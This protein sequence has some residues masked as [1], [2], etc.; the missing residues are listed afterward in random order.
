MAVLTREAKNWHKDFNGASGR[1]NIICMMKGL[2]SLRLLIFCILALVGAKRAHADGNEK[3]E[4]GVPCL[5][6]ASADKP[7]VA[8]IEALANSEGESP[9]VGFGERA[10]LCEDQKF[11]GT[12]G[13]HFFTAALARAKKIP[14]V[15]ADT[16]DDEKIAQ[17]KPTFNVQDY[18]CWM[19]L[20]SIVDG[21]PRD[22]EGTD[23]WAVRARQGAKDMIFQRTG[24]I[25][26]L[27][28]FKACYKKKMGKAPDLKR[29]SST[30][31]MP[32]NS[33]D[34]TPFQR[35]MYMVDKGRDPKLLNVIHQNLKK[36]DRVLVVYG[37][38]HLVRMM[39]ALTDMMGPP[40]FACTH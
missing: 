30:D 17:I 11:P 23:D 32:K 34:A 2:R 4:A 31:Y 40:D 13:E 38:G 25:L 36:R 6:C 14:Y 26:S 1:A 37:S 19:W 33:K 15:G 20:T 5:N 9:L 22:F 21:Q 27:E 39:D 24:A 12:C 7:Q 8:I 28:D 10:K 3:T 35:L 29:L 18:A 16:S